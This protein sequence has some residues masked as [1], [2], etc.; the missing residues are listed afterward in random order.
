MFLKLISD[1]NF[2]LL[3]VFYKILSSSLISVNP[4]PSVSALSSSIVLYYRGCLHLIGRKR[5]VFW[6]TCTNRQTHKHIFVCNTS[7][8]SRKEN[9]RKNLSMWKAMSNYFPL[10]YT[11]PLFY[12]KNSDSLVRN[13]P[14]HV[15]DLLNTSCCLSILSIC[16]LRFG[17]VSDN[18][19][20]YKMIAKNNNNR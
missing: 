20:C 10:Q 17:L 18:N 3:V 11:K 1:S 14:E 9:C 2:P 19:I 5:A 12:F 7:S 4:S 15:H 13:M 6:S 8:S 16:F